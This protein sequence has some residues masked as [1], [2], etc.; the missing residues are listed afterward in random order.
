MQASSPGFLVEEELNKHLFFPFLRPYR[1]E[2]MAYFK[3]HL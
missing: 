2:S 3:S 1:N